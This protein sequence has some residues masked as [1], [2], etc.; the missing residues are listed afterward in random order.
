MN[1]RFP[2]GPIHKPSSNSRS[3]PSAD[4]HAT[5]SRRRGYPPSAP[6]RPAD[7]RLGSDGD[8]SGSLNCR[9]GGRHC[10]SAS[11]SRR[12]R[13]RRG[14][15]VSRRCASRRASALLRV[16]RCNSPARWPGWRRG[17]SRGRRWTRPLGEPPSRPLLRASTAFH[18]PALLA[19]CRR[20]RG[21]ARRER[22]FEQRLEV[23]VVAGLLESLVPCSFDLAAV[24]DRV[25]D[26]VAPLWG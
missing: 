20:L 21:G 18:G 23:D 8:R 24:S 1:H 15:C 25:T 2:I 26:K 7:F 9:P 12:C 16:A 4:R 19:S 10:R 3:R 17:R 6:M 14:P 13:R 11:R 5:A 22:C